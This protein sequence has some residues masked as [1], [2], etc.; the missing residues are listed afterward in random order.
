MRAFFTVLHRWVGLFIAAFLF[1]A[2][3]TGTIIAWDAELDALLNPHLHRVESAGPAIPAVELARRVEA[4][5]PQVRVTYLPLHTPS[6]STQSVFVTPKTDPGT[7]EP[8]E[9]GWNQLFLDPATG[10][11]VGRREWGAAWPITRETLIPFLYE[12]HYNLHIPPMWGIDHWG[13]WLMGGIAI[14]WTLDC[15]VGFYLTLPA[16]RPPRPGRPAA[17]ERQL[18]RGWWP[19]W[20]VAWKIKTSASAYRINFDIHRAFGLWTWGLLFMLA[21]TSFSLNLWREIFYPVLSTVAEVS[22]RSVA[23]PP[24]RAANAVPAFDMVDIAELAAAEGARRGWT[25]PVGAISFAMEA[26]VYNPRFFGPEG[27]HGP[28]LGT[29]RLYYDSFTGTLLGD[30]VPGTGTAADIF[31]QAQFPLHSGRILGVPGRIVVSA[32]GL[33]VAALAI[34]GAVIWYRKF[35]ARTVSKRRRGT[36]PPAETMAAE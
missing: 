33:V 26:G 16:R 12:F 10:D 6:G 7:G 19:R 18:A 5:H 25:D 31:A 1:I 20:A 23:S 22:P 34:S 8:Y 29:R 17:V 21:F 11:E 28:D 14:L 30:R 4:D 13:E 32:M 36:R 9:L 35:R 3:V 24:P 2:G 15:F 27:D